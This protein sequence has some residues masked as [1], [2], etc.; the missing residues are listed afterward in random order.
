MYSLGIATPYSATRC[1]HCSGFLIWNEADE[2][3]DP[4]ATLAPPAHEELPSDV[5]VAYEEAAGIVNRSPRGAAALL[6]LAIHELCRALDE[7]GGLNEAIG[8]LVERGLDPTV[9]QALDVV[10]VVG[11]NAVHPGEIDVKDNAAIAFALFG[12]VNEV[13]EAMIARPRRIREL[14]ASL[15]SGSLRAIEKRDGVPGS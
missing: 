14:Y 3:V 12:L 2:L 6:R 13:T 1:S 4:A 5:A 9:Q 10:R 11:N 15:P 7:P 8:R